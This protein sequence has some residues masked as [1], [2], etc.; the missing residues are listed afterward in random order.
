MV[1][2][3]ATVVSHADIEKARAMLA[4]I[5]QQLAGTREEIEAIGKEIR[6]RRWPKTLGEAVAWEREFGKEWDAK[7]PSRTSPRERALLLRNK[8]RYYGVPYATVKE[9]FA[10][11]WA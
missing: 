1:R 5:Q 8:A 3:T 6:R 2:D 7:F 11:A 4:D 10:G 9:A